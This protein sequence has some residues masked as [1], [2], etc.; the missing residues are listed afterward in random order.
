MNSEKFS[1]SLHIPKEFLLQKNSSIKKNSITTSILV[2]LKKKLYFWN[3]NE[4]LYWM[5]QKNVQNLR[6]ILNVN[7]LQM[8]AFD[9]YIVSVYVADQ[10]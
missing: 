4:K 5:G 3:E 10:I 8:F 1:Q 6:I 7:V 2:R 9:S